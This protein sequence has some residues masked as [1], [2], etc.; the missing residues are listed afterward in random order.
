MSH[1]ESNLSLPIH[2]IDYEQLVEDLE[3]GTRSLLH[4]LGLDWDSAC[5]DFHL[6]NRRVKTASYEQ[7]RKPIYTSS[8][9]RWRNYDSW[10][11]PLKMALSEPW[12]S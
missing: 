12:N 8:V 9:G 3:T 1:W 4:F 7:V 5:L 10:L 11:G 6:S 2:V